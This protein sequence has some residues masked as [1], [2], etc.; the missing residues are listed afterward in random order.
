MDLN[1]ILVS[2][3]AKITNDNKETVNEGATVYGTY[4]V[5]GD[6]AYV[7]IDGSDTRTPVATTSEARN[8]DRV[9]V[10]IKNHRAI[11]TGNITD[12]S[13]TITTVKEVES[14]FSLDMTQLISD[15][16]YSLLSAGP[17]Y[18]Q[19]IDQNGDAIVDISD[20]SL[21][22][23]FRIM[24]TE[25]V[26]DTTKG[27]IANKNGIGWSSDGFKT[28]SKIGLDME[29]G[30]IYAD[31]IAAD[32]LITNSFQ[33]GTAMSFDGASGTMIAKNLSITGGSI[34][35]ETDGTYS[36]IVIR[37]DNKRTV[38]DGYHVYVKND[39]NNID[40]MISW[41]T[42]GFYNSSGVYRGGISYSSN[43]AV[44]LTCA[45]AYIDEITENGQLLSD[46]YA[47][48]YHNHDSDYAA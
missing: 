32:A 31:Q 29:N 37:Y 21:L 43:D 41:D 39:L 24:D 40:A 12:P 14:N 10:L 1:S 15:I 20:T 9:T 27:W 45:T 22:S 23:G 46:K 16:S 38:I 47:S 8:G 19:F 28:I 34:N 5:D 18:M 11:V 4:R 17:G 48:V 35:I 7:Q 26:T 30:R 44:H 3:F 33:I 42:I 13:A 25:E 2:E 36:P 6:G